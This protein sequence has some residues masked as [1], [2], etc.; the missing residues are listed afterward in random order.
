VRLSK[1]GLTTGSLRNFPQKE[2]KGAQIWSVHNR[3][4]KVEIS[5]ERGFDRKREENS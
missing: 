2:K 5:G 4:E 1:G 3:H